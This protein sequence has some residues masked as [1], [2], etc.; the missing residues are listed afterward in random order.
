MIELLEKTNL[1]ELF[2]EKKIDGIAHGVNSNWSGHSPTSKIL[3]S[4]YP[5]LL[6][7]CHQSL[8]RAQGLGSVSFIKT[9]NGE[10]FN[11][12]FEKIQGIGR[13]TNYEAFYLAFEE[14]KIYLKP[15]YR[16]G[17]PFDLGCKT[18]G[19]SWNII[20]TML[21]ELFEESEIKLI[22]CKND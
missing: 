1:I 21:I 11:L 19:G 13:K 18:S 12:C 3:L 9:K 10:I 15:G 20:L 7:S 4:Q 14:L 8:L 6:K 22:I 5:E 16:I 2:E 17:I